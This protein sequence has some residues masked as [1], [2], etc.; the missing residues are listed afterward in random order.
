MHFSPFPPHY[1]DAL[2]IHTAYYTAGTPNDHPIV[3][4]HGMTS[5]ADTYR[6][7]MHALDD[8]FWLIVPDI[9]GFGLSETTKPFT[10]PHLVEW[11][12]AFCDAL[13]LPPILLGGHSFGGALATSFTL[14]NPEDVERLLLI[15]PALL[16]IAEV[17]DLLK[18][19]G[20]NSGLLELGT[21]VSQSPA[22]VKR[23]AKISFYKPDRFD[24]TV[25]ERQIREYELARSSADVLKALAF[26]DFEAQLKKIDQSVC[27][28]WG[29]QDPVLPISH[30]QK[31]DLIC[32]DW[33]VFELDECGHIPMLEQEQKFNLIARQF[34]SGQAVVLPPDRRVIAVFGSSAP[35][36]GDEFYTLAY[37]V[38]KQLAAAG[39][40]VATGGYMGTMTA[41]SEGASAANG[42]VIGVVSDQ[43]ERFRPIGPNQWI[44]EEIR[45]DSLRDRLLHLVRDNMGMIVLPGGIGTL[46]EFSLAWSFL[47]TGEIEPRPLVLLGDMWPLTIEPFIA[48]GYVRPD[49]VKLLH[50][51]DTA[52]TAVRYIIENVK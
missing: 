43:I 20:I 5:S 39:F 27:V 44:E 26:Q 45:Y 10:L 37:Q 7:M 47:Q 3:M 46:S 29:Q 35:V 28:V 24:D 9:P 13:D 36:K 11:L 17:P 48:A 19:I 40:A 18:R 41:V 14:A 15:S 33:R 6:E 4:L 2:G 38:G 51:A 49:H 31:I 30:A 12:A 42:H 52:E 25:W 16:G 22:F 34:F 23:Q 8:Q 50:F 32:T 1:V 21:A